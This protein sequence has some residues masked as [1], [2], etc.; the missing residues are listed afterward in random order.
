MVRKAPQPDLVDLHVHSTASDGVYS[1][2]DVVRRAAEVGLAAIALTDHDT[3]AGVAEA[4]AAGEACGVEVIPAAEISTE[5]DDGACHILAYFID[6]GD[7]PLGAVLREARDGRAARNEKILQRLGA[8]GLALTMDEVAG[9]VAGG[10]VT[11]ANLAGAMIRKGYVKTWAEA[12]GRYLGRGKP[13]FVPRRQVM[14]EAA[15][16]AIHGAG[17]LAALAHPRQLN[18]GAAETEE[19]IER[20]AAAGLDAVETASPDHT[21]NYARRYR[22]CAERLGLLETGGSDWHGRDESGL[23]LG[24]GR[25]SMLVHYERVQKMKDRLAERGKA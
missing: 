1:P 11:R 23:H 17:G 9:G 10:T 7:A 21:A 19:W 4:L 3:V 12:F 14:P 15:L 6:C 22:A 20:L 18:R 25:G 8:A 2:G 13:A 16:A 24:L 5:F